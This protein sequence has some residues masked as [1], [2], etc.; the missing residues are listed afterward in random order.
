MALTIGRL[1]ILPWIALALSSA[2][3]LD[4][5]AVTVGN[6]A[7]TESEV[8]EEIRI[9]SLLNDEPLDFT[10]KGRRA[11]AER[12]VDQY[13]IR[14][15]LAG[16]TYASPN[17]PQADEL[18]ADFVKTHFHGRGE[19]EQKLKHYGVSE[20]ELKSHLLF[21]LQAI[22]F[23]D[24]RFSAGSPSEAD[25]A[26]TPPADAAAADRSAANA[27]TEAPDSAKVDQQLDEWLK[28]IRS[29]TR[30]EFKKEAFQ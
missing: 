14:R 19:F 21:Q 13:L 4:R 1:T 12:L 28:Q 8:M 18:L 22:A 15:E 25:R 27:P 5:V 30:I 20:D 6:D 29:Q 7:I 2:A 3:V 11:A 9:T 10:P 26:T 17:A 16:G 24:L 23:T